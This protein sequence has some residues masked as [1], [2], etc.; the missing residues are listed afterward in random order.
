[1]NERILNIL[2]A[3]LL[4]IAAS[5]AIWA[6][7]SQARKRVEI[8]KN[9]TLS[10]KLDMLTKANVAISDDLKK[11]RNTLAETITQHQ[12]TRRQLGEEILS[13]KTLAAKIHSLEQEADKITA[14]HAQ[15]I[16]QLYQKISQL[17]TAN[18]EL[19]EEIGKLRAN[20]RRLAEE[21]KKLTE[22]ITELRRQAE[23]AARPVSSVAT[24][25]KDTTIAENF[26]RKKY[27]FSW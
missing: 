10:V 7:G 4:G 11:I 23:A 6:I 18:I 21:N 5:S 1:M 17:K 13:N 22:E 16:E 15:T 2:I 25:E 24:T 27:N 12:Q 14:Q 3:L 19:G 8:A 9:T 20:A 26:T